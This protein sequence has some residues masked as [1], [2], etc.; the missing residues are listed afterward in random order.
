M[1][2]DM[3]RFKYVN[4]TLGH[5]TGDRLLERIAT[6]LSKQIPTGT[7][8]ARM[9][10][11]EFM[12]LF[13]HIKCPKE[14]IEA[15]KSL[16]GSLQE[17]FVID[18]YDL[19]ITASIGISIFPLDGENAVDLMKHA[20]IALYRAKDQGRNRY[21][22]YSTTMN[23]R[24][25]QSFLI[26]KDL[27]RALNE[28]QFEVYFQ[29]RVEAKTGKI[30]SAE[31]LL[32]WKHPQMGMVSPS[33]FIP[34][35]EETGLILPITTWVKRKVC[36]HLVHWREQGFPLLPISIN[37]SSQRFLQN[38][39]AK[40]VSDLLEQYALEGH[41]LEFEITENSLMKNEQFVIQTLSELKE[42]GIKILID[43]F[44]TGY[45]SF[46][47]LKSFPLDGIKIT[48]LLSAI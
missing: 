26:E 2:L 31:A 11:D 32:R 41:Y 6:R 45:S 15:A 16:T 9:G 10:G 13:P 44:G 24:T 39:F 23:V 12:I 37:I 22:I 36:E 5:T 38:D 35:A 8:L 33:E 40:E 18:Q 19:H 27:R 17:P 20:D 7:V 3:D 28:D 29:P 14:L 47:Y 48:V 46:F 4:D 1:Y 30:V 42:M 43:D 25:F 21:Q 34:L